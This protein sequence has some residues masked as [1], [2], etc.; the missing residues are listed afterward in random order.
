MYR[1]QCKT[2]TGAVPYVLSPAT[3]GHYDAALTPA[4]VSS[5]AAPLILSGSSNIGSLIM[6]AGSPVQPVHRETVSENRN[7]TTENWMTLV[8]VLSY[9]GF[10]QSRYEFHTDSYSPSS[11]PQPTAVFYQNNS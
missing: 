9:S 1:E 2:S 4:A 5:V 7:E 3:S 8:C 11:A 10:I 6:H